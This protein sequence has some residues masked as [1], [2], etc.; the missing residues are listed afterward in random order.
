MSF[1]AGNSICRPN[2]DGSVEI[3]CAHAYRRQDACVTRAGGRFCQAILISTFFDRRP[4]QWRRQ[5]SYC[6]Y[7]PLH[8]SKT[9]ATGM[10]SN[11]P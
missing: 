7:K 11:R 1:F 3:L 4:L 6:K 2:G 10:F 9:D 8:A 5:K